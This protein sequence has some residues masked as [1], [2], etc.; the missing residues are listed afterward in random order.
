MGKGNIQISSYYYRQVVG[1]SLHFGSLRPVFIN[2]LYLFS[3]LVTSLAIAQGLAGRPAPRGDYLPGDPGPGNLPGLYL[4]QKPA[5]QHYQRTNSGTAYKS[6]FDIT[7]AR[8]KWLGLFIC[9]VQFYYSYAA[10]A[11]ITILRFHFI[12]FFSKT[13]YTPPPTPGPESKP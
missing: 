9:K 6:R 10:Q 1:L 5:G 11:G 8:P 2:Y 4:R 12:L 7:K 13:I 3:F